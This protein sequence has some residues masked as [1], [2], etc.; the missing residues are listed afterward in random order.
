MNKRLYNKVL[1]CEEWKIGD[2]AKGGA[3]YLGR[4][5]QTEMFLIYFLF[6]FFKTRK[7]TV[8]RFSIYL[9]K[10]RQNSY[11]S[12]CYK[13]GVLDLRQYRKKKNPF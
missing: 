1:N 11:F 4:G 8:L 7:I 12:Y 3:N 10:E 2:K 5:V 13:V 6:L 9:R